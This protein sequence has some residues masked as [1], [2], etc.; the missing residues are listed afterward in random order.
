MKCP[1]CGKDLGEGIYVDVNRIG[2]VCVHAT[3]DIKIY[4]EGKAVFD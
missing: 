4:K 2:W 1:E 3:Y